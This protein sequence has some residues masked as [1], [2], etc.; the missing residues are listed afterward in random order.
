MRR[1]DNFDPLALFG[2][3]IAGDHQ[4]GNFAVPGLFKGPRHLRRG[5]ARPDDHGSSLGLFGQVAGNRQRRL[6]ALH[7]KL[8]QRLQQRAIHYILRQ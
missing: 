4:S 3:A 7:G 5:L 1:L 6:G 8:E 2:I